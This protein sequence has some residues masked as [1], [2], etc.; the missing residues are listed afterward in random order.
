[1]ITEAHKLLVGCRSEAN[2]VN[3]KKKI[4][5]AAVRYITVNPMATDGSC[6]EVATFSDGSCMEMWWS[7]EEGRLRVGARAPASPSESE[8]PAN[9]PQP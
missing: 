4:R 5:A 2:G 1:M 8:D 3:L 7:M 9:P 6:K